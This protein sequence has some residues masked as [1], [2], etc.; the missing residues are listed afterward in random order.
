MKTKI[1]ACSAALFF[2]I[3]GCSQGLRKGS[4][5]KKINETEAQIYIGDLD[6]KKG[7]KIQLFGYGSA[8][9]GGRKKVIN[10]NAEVIEV[11]QQ[12][13]MIK[14]NPEVSFGEGTYIEKID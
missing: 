1:I 8:G 6:L 13:A 7:D 9:R 2:I 5:T 11:K 12:Y 3:A 14:V 4:V 10:G